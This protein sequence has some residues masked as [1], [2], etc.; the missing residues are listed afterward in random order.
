[1]AFPPT[2][3]T[4]STST[5]LAADS[6]NT[7]FSSKTCLHAPWH[8]HELHYFYRQFIFSRVIKLNLLCI[9]KRPRRAS[10]SRWLAAIAAATCKLCTVCLETRWS[11][12]YSDRQ[13]PRR[14]PRRLNWW[15]DDTTLSSAICFHS[16]R[17]RGDS[18]DC[19]LFE[20][21]CATTNSM[22]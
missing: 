8:H 22:G 21:L 17:S 2:T 5:P 3:T 1:M 16:Q 7:L 11:M 9:F 20:L 19:T 15:W 18:C 10:K 13:Q 14:R 12:I 4:T 6:Q